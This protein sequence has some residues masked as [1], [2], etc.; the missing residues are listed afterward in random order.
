MFIET[1]VTRKNMLKLVLIKH[2]K[3]WLGLKKMYETDS[4]EARPDFGFLEKFKISVEK[5]EKL[6]CLNNWSFSILVT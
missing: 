3:D 2:K 6:I 4:P 1:T 5:D